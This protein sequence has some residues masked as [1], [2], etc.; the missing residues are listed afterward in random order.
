MK[1]KEKTRYIPDPDFLT[2]INKNTK[3]FLCLFASH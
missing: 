2:V 1:K 3:M